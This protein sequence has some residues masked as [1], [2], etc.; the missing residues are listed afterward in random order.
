MNMRAIG[1]RVRRERLAMDLSQVDASVRAGV[2]PRT[3]VDLE[4]G[5]INPTL[6]TLRAVCGVVGLRV[7]VLLAEGEEC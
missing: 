7:S 4:N 5:H 1:A 2:G 3:W 6:G